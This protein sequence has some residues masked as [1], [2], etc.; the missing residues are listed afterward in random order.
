MR[1]TGSPSTIAF[2]RDFK[3]RNAGYEQDIHELRQYWGEEP[4]ANKV[5]T[6]GPLQRPVPLWGGFG[7]PKGAAKAG[8]LGMGLL[9]LD[10]S[11]LQPYQE[12]LVEAGFNASAAR[13]A[14][15]VEI[16]VTDDPEK[17][18][19]EIGPH[20]LYRWSSLNKYMFEGNRFRGRSGD[21]SLPL[22]PGRQHP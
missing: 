1:D 12:G 4:G 21:E 2:G 16:V 11:L 15:H 18:W 10:P 7:G 20:V 17:A 9:S 5:V 13:M 6:P 14:T 19:A 3:G 8:R 22:L